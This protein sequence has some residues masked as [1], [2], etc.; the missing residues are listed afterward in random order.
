MAELNHLKAL[1]EQLNHFV[2][3]LRETHPHL[4]QEDVHQVLMLQGHGPFDVIS[5]HKKEKK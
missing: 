5:A 3:S 2:R 4:Y 1:A